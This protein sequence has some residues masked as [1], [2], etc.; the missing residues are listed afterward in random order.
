MEFNDTQD[1]VS[2]LFYHPHPRKEKVRN[3]SEYFFEFFFFLSQ[4]WHGFK[5]L[6]LVLLSS[7]IADGY[8]SQYGGLDSDTQYP[9]GGGV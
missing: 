5:V 3:T 1:S 6:V 8:S 4:G 9:H 7:G 2:A